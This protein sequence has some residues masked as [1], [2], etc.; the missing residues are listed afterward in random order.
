MSSKANLVGLGW[1]EEAAGREG[2][3]AVG[4]WYHDAPGGSACF[5]ARGTSRQADRVVEGGATCA[6]H[7]IDAGP[8]VGEQERCHVSAHAHPPATASHHGWW[9]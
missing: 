7:R 2:G 8:L 1:E 3:E 5:L 4:R 6:V 9:W